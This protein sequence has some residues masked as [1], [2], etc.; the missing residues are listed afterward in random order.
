[1]VCFNTG[2]TFTTQVCVFAECLKDFPPSSALP[3]LP[4]AALPLLSAAVLCPRVLSQLR[5]RQ[6]PCCQGCGL[7]P[8]VAA[9]AEA[10]LGAAGGRADQEEAEFVNGRLQM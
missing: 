9:A 1:M 7:T 10:L 8:A 5:S 3:E 4:L 6:L 2:H